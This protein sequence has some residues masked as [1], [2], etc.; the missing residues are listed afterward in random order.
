MY[1]QFPETMVVSSFDQKEY[2]VK[3]NYSNK[4]TAANILAKLNSINNTVIQHLEEKYDGTA[5]ESEVQFLSDNY[6]G[7]VLEE[8]MPRTTKNTSYVLNKGDL[9]KLCLRNPQT[10]QFH[11]F[12]TLL[13][14]NFHELSHL[15]DRRYGH[16]ESFWTSFKFILTEANQLGLYHPIDY[17]KTP[18]NYCGITI[19]G[20][21]FYSLY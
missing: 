19:D 6:D 12:D 3:R 13:F 17:K 20:N 8:H 14:V 15:L 7:D 9:I 2:S 5:F 10:K 4:E 16:N 18:A 21:P 11:D 1:Q